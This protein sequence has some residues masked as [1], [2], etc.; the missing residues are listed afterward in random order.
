MDASTIDWNKV[1]KNE[2]L[3]NIG[4]NPNEDYAS[5]WRKRLNAR[6]F[7]EITKQNDSKRI[8]RTINSLPITSES[9]VL[10]IGSG[11]GLLSLQIAKKAAHVTSVEPSKEMIGILKDNIN[12]YDV[13]NIKC[14]NKRWEDVDIETDLE[15]QYDVVFASYSLGM[16]DMKSAIMKMISASS[17]HV[18]LFWVAG[19]NLWDIY[20]PAIWHTLHNEEYHP[21]PKSNTLYNVLYQMGIY[22][23]VK[24]SKLDYVN[25]FS[26]LDEAVEYCLPMYKINSS[27][28]E[29]ILRDYLEKILRKDNDSLFLETQTNHMEIW[30]QK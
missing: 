15:C 9:K 14:I 21:M 25:K 4:S 13:Q 19:K 29:E 6:Q 24:V 7:Y 3:K 8:E 18:Y 27:S 17:N 1:W 11:P 10:D 23:N 30:W 28:Q 26:C 16:T 2:M 22:P 12:K 5:L 20:S